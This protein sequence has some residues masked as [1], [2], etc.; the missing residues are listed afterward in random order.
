M[1]FFFS[2]LCTVSSLYGKECYSILLNIWHMMMS[3]D[4]IS[5]KKKFWTIPLFVTTH[6]AIH[7][8]WVTCEYRCGWNRKTDKAKGKKDNEKRQLFQN[9]KCS[10]IFSLRFHSDLR[11]ISSLIMHTAS[12]VSY[13]RSPFIWC[14]KHLTLRSAAV[15]VTDLIKAL[16]WRSLITV[17]FHVHQNN[18]FLCTITI[19]GQKL[20]R[21]H[22]F[23]E[24]HDA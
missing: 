23:I 3:L 16:Y 2:S 4:D 7:D 21:A 14:F 12:G 9:R 18:I 11:W 17:Q 13:P 24:G 20:A 1:V 15:P 5:F 6:C 8:L 10:L 22:Y 19:R